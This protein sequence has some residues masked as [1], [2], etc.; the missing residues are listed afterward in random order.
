MSARP[1]RNGSTLSA[2]DVFCDRAVQ[3]RSSHEGKCRIQL[4][5]I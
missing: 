4:L 2:A 1:E 5:H 3:E